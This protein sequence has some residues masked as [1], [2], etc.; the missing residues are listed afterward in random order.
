MWGWSRGCT[1]PKECCRVLHTYFW[2][3]WYQTRAFLISVNNK[4][5]FSGWFD[6]FEW[7]EVSVQIEWM[8]GWSR[9]CT[10]PK[11]CC[12]LP[13]TY[14]VPH[15]TKLVHSRYQWIIKSDFSGWFDNSEI[16]EVFGHCR[17][18]WGWSRGCTPPNECC[19]LPPTYFWTTLHQTRAFL[20]SVS[21][22]SDFSGSFDNFEWGEVSGQIEW[23]GG[24][25]RGR[26][27][28][29]ECCRLPPTYFWATWHQTRA[30]LISVNNKKW[31][32]WL[33]RQF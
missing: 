31:F 10:P 14:F 9:G 20:I 21:N 25:S 7:G 28:P 13:P 5:D 8:G 27:P 32:I 11:E 1:Q 29:K 19:R 6:N 4:S 23:M 22:K 26:T 2:A 16:G 17:W 15:G 3:T 12:R 18:M 33:V 30:F 24:W